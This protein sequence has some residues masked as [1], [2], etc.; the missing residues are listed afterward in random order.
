MK[1]QYRK[2]KQYLGMIRDHRW[3]NV[4]PISQIGVYPCEYKTDNTLPDRALFRPYHAGEV[5]GDGYDTHAWFL[6]SMFAVS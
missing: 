6:K 3:E 1:D 4:T 5:W 2:V